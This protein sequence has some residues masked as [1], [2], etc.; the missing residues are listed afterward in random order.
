MTYAGQAQA[1]QAMRWKCIKAGAEVGL[2]WMTELRRCRLVDVSEP[3]DK[4]KEPCD[5]RCDCA[6]ARWANRALSESV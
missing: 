1:E 6:P 2:A 4:I 3:G 5:E